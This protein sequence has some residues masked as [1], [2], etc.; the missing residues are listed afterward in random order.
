MPH[1]DIKCFPRDLT[2]EQKTALADD[3]TAAIVRHLNS[4]DESVSVA[5]SQVQ[6]E[7]W[8]AQVWD[9]EIAPQMEVLIKK[10]GYSM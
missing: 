3:I 7:N 5:L 1:I 2:D 9:T 8:K 10:P 6:P 4:K